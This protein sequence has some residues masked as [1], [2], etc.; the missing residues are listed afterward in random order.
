MYRTGTVR[1]LYPPIMALRVRAGKFCYCST[2]LYARLAVVCWYW[3]HQANVRLTTKTI[4]RIARGEL[5]DIIAGPQS[6]CK[7]T[8]ARYCTVPG[9]VRVRVRWSL[10]AKRTVMWWN[11]PFIVSLYVSE[12]PNVTNTPEKVVGARCRGRYRFGTGTVRFRAKLR[13]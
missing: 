11:F 4:H 3:I 7:Q 10:V 6:I 8:T 13:R 2:L 12:F 9:C 5:P 1:V